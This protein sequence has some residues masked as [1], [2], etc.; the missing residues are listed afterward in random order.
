MNNRT[1]VSLNID[2]GGFEVLIPTFSSASR[3][4]QGKA[5]STI[6]FMFFSINSANVRSG[7]FV[8]MENDMSKRKHM[9]KHAVKNVKVRT[10]EIKITFEEI[11]LTPRARHRT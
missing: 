7:K 2:F 6:P 11:I 8:N 10:P 9:W 5:D 1:V 3:S 4:S